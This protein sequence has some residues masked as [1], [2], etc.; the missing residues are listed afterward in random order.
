MRGNLSGMIA[1]YGVLALCGGCAGYA[2]AGWSIKNGVP[3]RSGTGMMGLLFCAVGL[4]CGVFCTLGAAYLSDGPLS[5]SSFVS[6]VTFFSCSC[7]SIELSIV[8]IKRKAATQ[9]PSKQL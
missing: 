9:K 3:V 1:L 2:W 4:L 8:H 6:A 5:E 7:I